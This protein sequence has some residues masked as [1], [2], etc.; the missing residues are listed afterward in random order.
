MKC[1]H[2]VVPPWATDE[3]KGGQTSTAGA[4]GRGPGRLEE[5]AQ[6]AKEVLSAAEAAPQRLKDL[7]MNPH[8]IIP[9]SLKCPKQRTPRKCPKEDPLWHRP[10]KDDA[11]AVRTHAKQSELALARQQT[12]EAV[13]E[14]V[15]AK[16][17]LE[18]KHQQ[19]APCVATTRAQRECGIKE[20]DPGGLSSGNQSHGR[21]V[22]QLRREQQSRKEVQAALAAQREKSRYEEACEREESRSF[23]AQ[24]LARSLQQEIEEAEALAAW[25]QKCQAVQ[26]EVIAQRQEF[27]ARAQQS[28]GNDGSTG[29]QIG[30]DVLGDLKAT[31]QSK[32]QYAALRAGD[33]ELR[34]KRKQEEARIEKEG[35]Y[36][37]LDTM[38][39]SNDAWLATRAARRHSCLTKQCAQVL[40]GEQ[41]QQH[42][43]GIPTGRHR[44]RHRPSSAEFQA[45]AEVVRKQCAR[46]LLAQMRKEE[47]EHRRKLQEVMDS[48]HEQMRQRHLAQEEEVL[49]QQEERRQMEAQA[50]TFHLE[51]RLVAEETR[52]KHVANAQEVLRQVEERRRASSSPRSARTSAR[53]RV[54]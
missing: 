12:N 11:R 26:E 19:I 50:K 22:A 8:L 6:K 54:G 39:Q 51:Q 18:E 7:L 49:Q 36:A 21:Y 23:A 16:R 24:Q 4:G 10:G 28:R 41:L 45:Q 42:G 31:Q 38:Q 13:Q 14:A 17:R 29:Y 25:R 5:T 15:K 9:A 46:K 30:R 3:N 37:A 35:E 43:G 32:W 33:L 44:P 47:A 48:A 20:T 27:R 1:D 2:Q 52:R 34:C 53:W 40:R